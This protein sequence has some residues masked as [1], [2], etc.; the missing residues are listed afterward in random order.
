MGSQNIGV[1]DVFGGWA[2]KNIGKT[3]V[4]EGGLSKKSAKPMSILQGD[5][6][7]EAGTCRKVEEEVGPW[8]GVAYICIYIG[9]YRDI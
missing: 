8:G 6:H 4:F 9:I 7:P 3:N 1:T 2:S 5:L